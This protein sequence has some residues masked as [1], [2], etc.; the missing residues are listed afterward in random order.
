MLF[1]S[2]LAYLLLFSVALQPF[3]REMTVIL[4]EFNKA[5]IVKNLCENR[6]R[7]QLHCGG[8]CYLTKQLKAQQAQPDEATAERIPHLPVMPWFCTDPVGFPLTT[9]VALLPASIP[10]GRYTES[11]TTSFLPGVFQPPRD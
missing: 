7:P 2:I 4:F 3:R 11:V 8:K 5:Y 10:A 9:P 1:R 6:N